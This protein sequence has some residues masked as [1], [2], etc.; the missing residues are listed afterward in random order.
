MTTQPS[1]SDALTHIRTALTEIETVITPGRTAQ[2]YALYKQS[3]NQYWT[4]LISRIVP[5]QS[6]TDEWQ[7][8][9]SVRAVYRVGNMTEVETSVEDLA[10]EVLF[11][12]VYEFTRRPFLQC[13]SYT[14]GVLGVASDGLQVVSAEIVSGGTTEQTTLNVVLTLTIPLLFGYNTLTVNE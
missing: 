11:T 1:Y 7:W 2:G 5:T 6:I 14:T 4:N 8:D 10:Q 13:S 12:A 3:S 9:L